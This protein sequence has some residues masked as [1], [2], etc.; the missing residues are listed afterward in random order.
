MATQFHSASN[1]LAIVQSRARALHT[2]PRVVVAEDDDEMRLLIVSALRRDGYEVQEAADG[3]RLLSLLS[4][5][6][7]APGMALDLIVADIRMPV[8]NGLKVLE[9]LRKMHWTVPVILMT[10]FGDDETRAEAALLGAI[11]FDKPF[12]MDD[13]RTAVVNLL[14]S[15]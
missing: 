2:P 9:T 4:A 6:A 10:A 13:L 15:R 8:C 14:P 11:L 12:A 5:P 3:G 7:G 1:V